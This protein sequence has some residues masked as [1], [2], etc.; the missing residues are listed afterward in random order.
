MRNNSILVISNYPEI[1]EDISNKLKLLRNYDNAKVVSYIEAISI[2]K[3][4]H[5]SIILIYSSKFDTVDIIKEVKAINSLG[6]IPTIFIT[7][8]YDE[9]KLLCAFEEGIDDFFFLTDPE[10]IILMRIMSTI[11]KSN[12]YIENDIQKSIL[13]ASNILDKRNKFFLRDTGIIAIK[14]IFSQIFEKN[15][16]NAY[17]MYLRVS[18]IKDD[19]PDIDDIANIITKNIRKNDITVYDKESGFY[20][21][22]YNTDEN[23]LKIIFNKIFETL[24]ANYQL[25]ACSARIT[26]SFEQME[27]RLYEETEKQIETNTVYTYICDIEEKDVEN[28]FDTGERKKI[29]SDR[30]K[31]EFL[32]NFENVTAPVFYRIQTKYND[33]IKDATIKYIFSE[34]E[35]KFIVSGK[36][37]TSELIITYPTNMKIIADIRH[38]IKGQEPQIKRITY[39]FNELSEEKTVFLLENMIKEYL[40]NSILD[41]LYITE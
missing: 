1:G 13:I 30:L 28:I 40:N 25:Y 33:K 22:L 16:D 14:E 20:L 39:N 26:T 3:S 35:S 6:N 9:E 41:K 8:E 34:N 24:Q 38:F 18:G 32:R 23:G 2:S 17:L 10:E 11:Q 27:L 19:N 5:P 31:E 21:I 29:N 36:E 7:D 4:I 15:I 12:L 37:N